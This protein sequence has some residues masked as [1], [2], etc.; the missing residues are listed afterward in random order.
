MA[1]GSDAGGFFFCV[2]SNRLQRGEP[3]L[4]GSR[5]ADESRDMEQAVGRFHLPGVT[6]PD[7][8]CSLVQRAGDAAQPWRH[9]LN[10]DH[11]IYSHIYSYKLLCLL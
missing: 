3:A 4:F 1:A 2:A 5:N 10:Q 11:D 9:R 8:D 6:P 7:D